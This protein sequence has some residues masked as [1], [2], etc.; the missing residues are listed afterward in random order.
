MVNVGIDLHKT[1]FTTCVRSQTGDRFEQYPTTE[2]GY[3]RFLKEVAGW[4][5][6]GKEV[7]VGVESTGN[8]RYF[9][10][11]MEAAGVGVVVI[12]TLKFKVV[13][14]SV[15][16][17][18][19]H[20]AATIAEFLEKDMLPESRLCSR[21]SE[22]LRRL[23]K[24]RTTPV[25]AEVVMKN[26]IHALLT[27]E[28]IQDA[29][30]SLQSKRGRQRVLDTLQEW[31]NGLVAQ[32]LVET[33]ERL[34]ENVKAI[35]GQLRTLTEG[36]RMVELL[37]TIPGCGEV[38]AWTIRAYTD[39]IGRFGNA[40]KYAAFAGLVPWV[41]DSNER[42]HHGKITKRGPEELRTALI[43]V[44]LGL[45]R[46]KKTTVSWRLMQRYEAMKRSKGTGKTITATARKLAVIIWHMLNGGREFDASLMED[47]ELAK[48]S[49]SMSR[50]ECLARDAVKGTPES[51]VS[52]KMHGKDETTRISK[53]GKKKTGVTGK[54]R[55][56]VG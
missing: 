22:R 6:T 54:K 26:R 27:A 16:K 43:Q 15:K 1:Q 46:C 5:G 48:K 23:L 39:D 56:K 25:R 2:E 13:N 44:V 10:N 19:K 31:E 41:Q 52:K 8:T 29:K 9:K 14:E 34:E 32:P 53:G 7:R 24:A 37:Q 20:D 45:R 38:C 36:D 35:E 18:D 50:T 3:K 28:G 33:I 4:Q 51:P 17:T 21:T 30:A 40:K 55:K 12:N 49:E 42:I 11:R 47:R